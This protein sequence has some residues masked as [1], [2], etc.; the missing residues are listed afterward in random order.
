MRTASRRHTY[1]YAPT[2]APAFLHTLA[3]ASSPWLR[4]AVA[5]CESLGAPDE[6]FPD[7][8]W[9]A[10]DANN[11]VWRY[12]SEWMYGIMFWVLFCVVYSQVPSAVH[13]V[14]PRAVRYRHSAVRPPALLVAP[15]IRPLR[16]P[17]GCRVR[18]CVALCMGPCEL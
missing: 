16:A 7:G 18:V 3:A 13:T 5:Q 12:A 1:A 11:D 8:T 6:A 2:P 14:A 15:S 10:C 4:Q 17:M 9:E